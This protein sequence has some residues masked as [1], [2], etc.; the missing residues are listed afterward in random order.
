MMPIHGNSTEPQVGGGPH[1]SAHSM[2]AVH[3]FA[4]AT[5]YARP[6]YL[7]HCD[8]VRKRQPSIGT[9]TNATVS[10]TEVS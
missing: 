3:L 4:V 2:L 6:L 8:D 10:D 5:F 9:C 7:E 1:S